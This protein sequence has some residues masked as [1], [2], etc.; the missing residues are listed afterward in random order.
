VEVPSCPPGCICDAPRDE[1]PGQTGSTPGSA[2]GA[3]PE[4]EGPAADVEHDFR[5]VAC[6]LNYVKTKLVLE[7][8]EAGQILGILL[9]EEGA[10]NVP[11]SAEQDGHDVLRVKEQDG[12]WRVVIRKAGR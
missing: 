12:H 4:P 6:P 7:T 5:G 9:D 8:M 2:D 11:A 10:G 3:V 1:A